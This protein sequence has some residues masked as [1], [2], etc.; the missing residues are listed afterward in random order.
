MCAPIRHYG[1]GLALALLRNTDD[2]AQV[3]CHGLEATRIQSV[4]ALLVDRLPR[5]QVIGQQPPKRTCSN[6]PAQ[7]IED[8]AQIVLA[9]WCE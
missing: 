6:Q 3:R 9:L 2:G 8:L 4:P 5:R 7:S 1:T